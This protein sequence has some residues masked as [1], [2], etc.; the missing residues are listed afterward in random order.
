VF[1]LNFR[2]DRRA[3]SVRDKPLI[4]EGDGLA[5]VDFPVRASFPPDQIAGKEVVFAT[6]GFNV[7]YVDGVHSLARLNRD[8]NLPSSF[9]FVGVLWPGDWWIPVINYPAEADDAVQCGRNLATFIAKNL[10]LAADL[11]FVSHSLGAR[12]VLEAVKNLKGRTA[13]EVCV[14]AAAADDDCLTSRQY[15]AAREKAKRISVLASKGDW[16]LQL[17]YPAGDFISDIF[18]DDDSPF[19]EALGYHG[20]RPFPE[21]HVLHAQ[22]P[23]R[24]YT[25]FDYFPPADLTQPVTRAAQPERFIA[26]ALLGLPHVWP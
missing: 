12:V 3:G 21:Q 9:T 14:L 2:H 16:V 15:D 1:F 5:T 22:I 20:P 6:H 24:V 10:S 19:R 17:A 8:L 11:S 4:L 13:R 7:D 18:Y 26:E 25:H 23:G